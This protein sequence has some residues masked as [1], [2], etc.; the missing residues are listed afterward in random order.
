MKLVRFGPPG[1]ER[2]GV[3]LDDN[4]ILDA[5]AMAFDIDDF[6]GP[7]FEKHGLERLRALLAERGRKTAPAEGVRLGP[8][9]AR[10]GKIV[11]L[12]KN[13]ADHA[14]EFDAQLPDSPILF[15]KATTAIIGPTDP[16]VLPAGAAEVDTEAELAIVIGR[17]AKG[18]NEN[19]AMSHVAGLTILNDVTD[20]KA[21]REGKQ[22]FHGKSCDTFCPLGPW[23]VTLD[24]TGDPHGLRLLSKIR[25]QVLQNAVA[26]QMIFKIPCLISFISATITLEAGDI[27]ATGTPGGIGSARKPPVLLQ[28]GDVA[29]VAIDRLGAQRNPAL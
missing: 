12:G 5:R 25:G 2:P 21:Q 13:Y 19:E 18:V 1:E 3:L 24:E 7:F 23:L 20:R 28:R 27:I 29:E 4:R 10:P 9:V 22:W 6:D 17:R 14:A 8:P 16:I 26:S 11:C 15:S